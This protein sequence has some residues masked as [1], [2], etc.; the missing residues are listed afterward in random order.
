M[1]ALDPMP[2]RAWS[3]R[4]AA[5]RRRVAAGAA[6]LLC[7]AML[8]AC[9]SDD[10]AETTATGAATAAGTTATPPPRDNGLADRTAEEILGAG[11]AAARRARSVHVAGAV[12]DVGIDLALVRDE[13]AAGEIAQ[14]EHR[15]QLVAVDGRLYIRGNEAFYRQMGGDAAVRLL[16]GRWLTASTRSDELGELAELVDKDALLDE[17]LTPG[18]AIEKD[19]EDTVD[20]RRALVLRN[21]SGA[22]LLIAAT[23]EPY[24]LRMVDGRGEGELVFDR[25]G[26][27]VELTAPQDAVDIS[28]LRSRGG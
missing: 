9:G 12:D 24:P 23:G 22:R 6:V 27:P 15:F 13:G 3:R 5:R 14:G 11:T 7:A 1:H 26:E 18:S 2:V 28:E 20:G 10:V 19:G 21:A 4:L 25:W 8:A 17:A 16:G